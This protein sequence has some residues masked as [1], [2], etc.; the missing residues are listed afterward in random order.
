MMAE[1][2]VCTYFLQNRCSYGEK[3]RNSHQIKKVC[4]YFIENR[5]TYGDKCKN[6]HQIERTHHGKPNI[7]SREGW[8]RNFPGFGFEELTPAEYN[9][10]VDVFYSKGWNECGN[11]YCDRKSNYN[12]NKCCGGCGTPTGHSK[13]CNLIKYLSKHG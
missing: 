12:I 11:G 8:E 10:F 7:T 13:D 2:K 9:S 5:C 6:L 3:C 4:T 1:Q